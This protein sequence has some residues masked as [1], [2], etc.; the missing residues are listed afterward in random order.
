M[1]GLNL[2]GEADVHLPKQRDGKA[3]RPQT[4]LYASPVVSYSKG[5]RNV[6]YNEQGARVRQACV[7]KVQ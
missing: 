6:K 5:E 7:E 4:D 2:G 3:P 1:G